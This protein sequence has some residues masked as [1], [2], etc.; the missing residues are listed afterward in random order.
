MVGFAVYASGL[1]NPFIEDDLN[2]IVNNVPVHSIANILLFFQSG[3][4]FNGQLNALTQGGFFRPLMTTAFAGLYTAFAANPFYFHLFQMVLIIGTTLLIYLFLRYSFKPLMALVLAL[5]FLVHPMNSQDV[6]YIAATGDLLY[7]FFGMLALWLLIRF[8]SLRSMV[9]ATACLFCS[10]L[11]KESGV[12]F[13]VMALLYLFWFDRERLRKFIIILVPAIVI[14]LALRFH[15]VGLWDRISLA[16]ID[17]LN[18]GQR[19]MTAPSIMSFYIVKFLFPGSLAMQYYWIYPQFSLLH[20]ALPLIIDIAVIAL[21]VLG[22]RR[23]R[24]IA[25]RGQYLSYLFFGTWAAAGVLPCLQIV[26]LDMTA[27]ETWF[28]FSM[29]G[30]LGMIGIL[31]VAYQDR[32]QWSWL[33]VL[34]LAIICTLGARTA[35]RGLDWHDQLSFSYK[36]IAASPGDYSAYND[37]AYGL[38][39]QNQYAQAAS[40]SRESIAIYPSPDSYNNLGYSL[41]HLGQFAA[42]ADAYDDG[43]RYGDD[44]RLY[45]GR[46]WLTLV[47]GSYASNLQFLE[48][49]IQKFPQDPALLMY[50]AILEE[51]HGDNT[52]AKDAITKAVNYGPGQIPESLYDDI[53]SNQKLLFNSQGNLIGHS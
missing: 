6:Y 28:S 20:V 38:I 32:F 50:Y 23:L 34:S 2:Q 12:L 48:G 24:G 41:A 35:V 46:G 47:Y 21:C 7:L 44:Y 5:I 40:Y 14:Y 4:F 11:S 27:C 49:A 37:I 36:E 51:N 26:S 45:G 9:A 39:Q 10:L 22:A 16:P 15:A 13:V 33:S 42:A 8:T 29:I 43:I 1:T 3:T 31:L 17:N 53:I 30:V 19:L 18:L 52:V 25:S